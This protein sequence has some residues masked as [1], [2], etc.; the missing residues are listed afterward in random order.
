MG[1]CAACDRE[2]RETLALDST[3]R[4]DERYTTKLLLLG[5]SSSGKSTFF[6]QMQYIHGRD[7][8][9]KEPMQWIEPIHTQIVHSMQL[10][11]KMYHIYGTDEDELKC[12]NLTHNGYNASC[13]LEALLHK[14]STELRLTSEMAD[15]IQILWS[16]KAIRSLFDQR[17]RIDSITGSIADSCGYF[18]DSMDRIKATGYIPSWED[19]LLCSDPTDGHSIHICESKGKAYEL[20]DV[21]GALKQRKQWIHTFENVRAVLFVAS[22]SSFDE[23]CWKAADEPINA[24]QESLELFEQVV[25][26]PW[27]RNAY[28]I[29]FFN[30]NDLFYKKLKMGCSLKVCF[31]N[32]CIPEYVDLHDGACTSI[33]MNFARNV[34]DSIPTDVIGLIMTYISVDHT[35]DEIYSQSTEL[36]RTQYEARYHEDTRA[37][38]THCMCAL[39]TDHVEKIFNDVQK[40]VIQFS[41]QNHCL[42]WDDVY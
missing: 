6:K 8:D 23:I 4:S 30:K 11:L 22:L 34:K 18:W 31:E 14:K 13:E 25:N 20:W 10:L 19:I 16:E 40:C 3:K 21:G 24:M 35:L 5:S 17:G 33:I 36:I 27:F 26:N 9:L 38:F 32:S 15:C 41:L 12:I 37:I 2:Q 42:G 1:S 28:L 29:L 7:Y 39:D